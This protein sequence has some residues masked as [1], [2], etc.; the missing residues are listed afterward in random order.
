MVPV[1]V[2]GGAD[3]EFPTVSVPPMFICVR[4]GGANE[5]L[6]GEM[7]LELPILNNIEPPLLPVRV[8]SGPFKIDMMAPGGASISKMAL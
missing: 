1:Y 7:G 8:A 2:P 4:E 3:P 5:L 6:K